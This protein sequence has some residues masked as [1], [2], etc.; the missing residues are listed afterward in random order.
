MNRGNKPILNGIIL[1]VLMIYLGVFFTLKD[2]WGVAQVIVLVL[3][4]GLAAFQYILF[5]KFF[6]K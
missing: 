6:R 5:F 1:T 4:A 2:M 3:L